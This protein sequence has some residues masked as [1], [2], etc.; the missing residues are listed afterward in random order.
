MAAP[1]GTCGAARGRRSGRERRGKR[2][3]AP[4]QRRA[5]CRVRRDCRDDR[6]DCRESRRRDYYERP[7]YAPH[8]GYAPP[9]RRVSRGSRSITPRATT[10]R[11]CYHAPRLLTCRCH[12]GYHV[13]AATQWAEHRRTA[14]W[15][16][17]VR[18][19][20]VTSQAERLVSTRCRAT[21]AG[22]IAPPFHFRAVRRPADI[23]PDKFPLT[24]LWRIGCAIARAHG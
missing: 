23:G 2:R 10:R 3:V 12:P 8:Y 4:P 18:K 20:R 1:N 24:H 11:R 15:Q 19:S 5:A 21:A 14:D 16:P 22:P 13:R 17:P 7:Y 9:A 6:S